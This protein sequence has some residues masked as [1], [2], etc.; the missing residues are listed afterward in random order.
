L[1]QLSALSFQ[2]LELL[3]HICGHAGALAAVDLGLLEL[4][5]EGMGR[6]ADLVGNR[7]HSRPTGWVLPAMLLHHPNRTGTD[8]N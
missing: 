3:G 5:I 4:L 7:H 2:N 6:A 8:L 1:P